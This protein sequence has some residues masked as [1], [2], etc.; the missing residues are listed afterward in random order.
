MLNITFTITLNEPGTESNF[1]FSMNVMDI[2]ELYASKFEVISNDIP[3]PLRRSRIS[4]E[5][6]TMTKNHR[7]KLYL[8]SNFVVFLL[9]IILYCLTTLFTITGANPTIT[10]ISKD[11]IVNIGDNLELKCTIADSLGYSFGWTRID[12]ST[13]PSRVTT[14]ARGTSLDVP[15]NRFQ[16]SFDQKQSQY[17]LRI[18]QLN[19]NDAGFYQCQVA[20]GISKAGTNVFVRIPPTI[21]DNSTR[22][23]ITSVGS[24]FSM[25]CYASGY[26]QPT[27]SWRRNKNSLIPIQGGVA[28]HRGNTLTLR[29]VTKSDRGTYYCVADNGVSPGARRGISVEIEF[30]PVVKV[31]QVRYEQALQY[32]ADLHCSV[33]AFPSPSISWVKD[34]QELSNNQHYSVAIF[35]T[36]NEF[37]QTTLRVKKIEKRQYGV[38]QCRAANKF[39]SSEAE[40]RLDETPNVVCPPACDTP[41]YLTSPASTTH[42]KQQSLYSL[43]FL[44]FYASVLINY[45]T[46]MTSLSNYLVQ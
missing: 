26:P 29:N 32:D 9:S 14:I 27:I 4:T 38:Y 11:Q 5:T 15:S 39:G 17:S 25:N 43:F 42:D 23:V 20:Q 24:D 45:M 7:H 37:S 21:S 8:M 31:G 18:N 3:L 12:K 6:A 36:S 19:E 30:K 2:V 34:G 41:N 40:V 22:S 35:D 33:E 28:I 13:S 44:T 16:A 10:F 1:L 46:K